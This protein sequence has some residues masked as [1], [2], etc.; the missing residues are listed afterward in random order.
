M[1][2]MAARRVTR[3]RGGGWGWPREGSLSG[4]SEAGHG[5]WCRDRQ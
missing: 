4:R 5:E 1:R 2:S 3:R